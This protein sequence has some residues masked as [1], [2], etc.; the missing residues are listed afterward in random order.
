M[1][2]HLQ[3]NIREAKIDIAK[4]LDEDLYIRYKCNL[5]STI[6]GFDEY[7]DVS[8]ETRED[9]RVLNSQIELLG[10]MNL[11]SREEADA[12]LR[13]AAQLRMDKLK[14]LEASNE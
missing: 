13:E 8:A 14:E 6:E 1:K 11:L 2:E 12:I 3:S 9:L 5:E 4:L 7:E 10:R